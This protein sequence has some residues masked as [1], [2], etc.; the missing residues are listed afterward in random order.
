MYT[1][2][3]CHFPRGFEINYQ[4]QAYHKIQI[5]E[6]VRRERMQVWEICGL[7]IAVVI[8]FQISF[9]LP[10]SNSFPGRMTW[11]SQ[12]INPC[13][14]LMNLYNTVFSFC[15]IANC[16]GNSWNRSPSFL[17]QDASLN[18]MLLLPLTFLSGNAADGNTS[19]HPLPI[20]K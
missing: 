7:Q 18:S 20:N 16:P 6:I 15:S 17:I 13:E 14:P 9:S 1:I 3:L 2:Y 4:R 12:L 8:N 11:V 10:S 5:L 19:Y